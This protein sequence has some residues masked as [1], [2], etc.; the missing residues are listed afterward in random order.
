MDSSRLHT[1]LGANMQPPF[2]GAVL[3]ISAAEIVLKY[4][5]SDRWWETPAFSGIPEG[6]HGRQLL[7]SVISGLDIQCTP[8]RRCVTNTIDWLCCNVGFRSTYT[9]VIN[10]AWDGRTRRSGYEFNPAFWVNNW[11]GW[12]SGITELQWTNTSVTPMTDFYFPL[13]ARRRRINWGEARSD[14]YGGCS[15]PLRK[16]E[17]KPAVT[18]TILVRAVN[19]EPVH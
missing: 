2:L 14:K 6:F 19:R 8:R 5:G 1:L 9:T 4:P 7:P 11:S 17:N 10:Q 3:G 13:N 12:N 16:P 18:W 15:L